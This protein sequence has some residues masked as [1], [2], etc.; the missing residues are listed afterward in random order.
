MRIAKSFFILF[1]ISF[2]AF[3]NENYSVGGR[4]SKYQNK[5][6]SYLLYQANY[7]H[8]EYG[9]NYLFKKNFDLEIVDF[10][11]SDERAEIKPRYVSLEYL[12]GK[13]SFE[14]GFLRYRFSE[15]FGF[16]ILDVANPRDYSESILGDLDMSKR[17]VFGLNSSTKI[18]DSTLFFYLTLW[19]NSDKLPY[20]NSVFNNYPSYLKYDGGTYQKKFLEDIEY[21]I[22]YKTLLFDHLDLGFLY[23]HHE[24]RPTLLKL[25]NNKL[26]RDSKMVDSFGLSMSYAFDELVLRSDFLSSE[27]E[28]K[29]KRTEEGIIGLDRTFDSLKV[30][31]QT[32]NHFNKGIHYL[33]THL[34]LDYEDYEIKPEIQFFT[35]TEK[36]DL[37]MRFG[38]RYLISDINFKVFYDY[39]ESTE[40]KSSLIYKFRDNKKLTIELNYVF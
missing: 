6:Y 17:A 29:N 18:N 11:N 26:V 25:D 24:R 8:E 3:G 30:G 39:L 9:D 35:N 12:K 23:Y 2:L 31:L 34:E 33:G 40:K 13:N 4:T 15:T 7:K 36:R 16:Q 19:G 10:L 21:G 37:W 1:F 22:R 38:F 28:E 5:D 32:Y 27:K 14:I 20:K